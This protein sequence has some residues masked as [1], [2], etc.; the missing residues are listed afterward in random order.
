MWKTVVVLPDGTEL[1]SGQTGTAA[2]TKFSLTQCVNDSKELTMGQVCAA[3]AEV[4]VLGV[5]SLPVSPG[6]NLTVYRQDSAGNRRQ[7]GIFIA[8]QPTRPTP[9]TVHL[10]AYDRVICLDRD[11]TVWLDSLTGWPYTLQNLARLLCEACGVTLCEADLPNGCFPVEK[12]TAPGI[13]GRQLMGYI[14]ELTGRFCRA[15]AQGELEFA[16][17]TPIDRVLEPGGADYYLQNG[18]SYEDY[19]TA[20]IERVQLR[21]N[22]EDVGTVYPAEALG[23][24]T[25]VITGNPLAPARNAGSLIGVAQTLYEQLEGVRYTP[26]RLTLPADSGLAC[27]QIVTVKNRDGQEFTVYVMKRKL[28]GGR[29]TIEC[30][31]SHYR[32]SAAAVNQVGFK[33]LNG[34]VLNLSATVDGIRVEN[35]DM[36][37]KVAGLFLDVEG[38][39]SRVSMQQTNLS[40]LHTQL[41]TMEQS[42]QAVE[43]RVQEMTQDGVKKVKTETGFTLD[44]NGLTISREGTRMENLLN[45]SGMYVR[46]MGEVLL[47]AD[48]E[49][50]SA[51]DVSV[52]NY[53]IVGDH[54]R[55]EDYENSGDSKRTAC[56]W[57]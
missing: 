27:G 49:G 42:A 40:G 21:Q 20:P 32:D 46:R 12:F 50:V 28:S 3:M 56:F 24:N 36:A 19:E 18:F 9:N 37:G 5:A 16:W 52:G 1:S 57:I 4:T 25:Y 53:L 39:A 31:G 7:V 23:T 30:T 35:R 43:I 44:A 14:G 29:E 34:K 22:E 2:I 15:N 6:D 54:A 13:T 38:I 45:E 55:F 11:M 10:T 48:Q 41:T 8:Q 51:V 17:Y 47:K 26:C 33:A